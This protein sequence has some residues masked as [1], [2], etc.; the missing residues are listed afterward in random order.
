MIHQMD[1]PEK[2]NLVSRMIMQQL[3]AHIT[4]KM[5]KY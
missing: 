2:R 1:L 5:A 4:G 3:K